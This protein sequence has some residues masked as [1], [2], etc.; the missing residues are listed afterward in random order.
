MIIEKLTTKSIIFDQ[1][2]NK[3]NSNAKTKKTP[4]IKKTQTKTNEKFKHQVGATV[5]C[6][7][8]H[9]FEPLNLNLTRWWVSNVRQFFNN[10][11]VYLNEACIY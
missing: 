10:Y 6:V 2:K 9:P 7:F 1:R 4:T 5:N 3:D 8:S 11:P